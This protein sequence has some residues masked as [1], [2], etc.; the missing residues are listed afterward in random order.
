MKTVKVIK[1][2][3]FP[4]QLIAKIFKELNGTKV[5]I[6]T[7]ANGVLVIVTMTEP[8]KLI[9]PEGWYYSEGSLRNNHESSIGKQEEIPMIRPNGGSWK[10]IAKYTTFSKK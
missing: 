9:Y 3:D 8:I 6:K 7:N 10:N 2:A 5:E 4:K 1:T